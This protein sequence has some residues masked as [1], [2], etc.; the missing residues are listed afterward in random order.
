MTTINALSIGASATSIVSQQ[1][2]P[3]DAPA[4][5]TATSGDVSGES[6]FSP[7][8]LQ[9][10][11]S[12]QT[13]QHVAS[14][15][16]QQAEAI[17]EA[18]EE[19]VAGKEQQTPSQSLFASTN[20]VQELIALNHSKSAA[21]IEAMKQGIQS[22]APAPNAE[23]ETLKAP[24][25]VMLSIELAE[26]AV[27][28]PTQK[29]T[30]ETEM[31]KA[32]SK[33]TEQNQTQK[34]GG[35]ANNNPPVAA[36]RFTEAKLELDIEQPVVK[37]VS[38]EKN[39]QPTAILQQ[40][41][42][43]MRNISVEAAGTATAKQAEGVSSVIGNAQQISSVDKQTKI[44]DDSKTSSRKFEAGHS[45]IVR[46]DKVD[47][48]KNG[49]EHIP[50]RQAESQTDG[51]GG[52]QDIQPKNR[53]IREQKQFA[54][55]TTTGISG[56]ALDTQEIQAS[57]AEAVQIKSE[58]AQSIIEQ[59]SKNISLA[60]NNAKSEMKVVLHPESLGEVV[61]RVQVEE[62]KV[63][64]QLDVQQQQVK[65]MIEQH[66]PQLKEALA[67]K[68]LTVER[69]DVFASELSFKEQ[70]SQQQQKKNQSGSERVLEEQEE[71]IESAK[72]FGYN[73][74]EYVV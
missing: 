4:E 20:A 51:F 8:L 72:L 26:E 71:V 60:L 61:V 10:I 23:Q 33:S 40:Q 14:N 69:I 42:R 9:M 25:G 38:S 16:F 15:Q 68:G 30:P 31:L 41:T 57:K 48:A 39:T 36:H 24:E 74:I 18:M 12:Q 73:T 35:S 67:N 56:I 64:T 62:G 55:H 58:V 50:Q 6:M 65:N 44:I 22:F 2:T 28:I 17:A 45:S 43:Q 66:L 7:L 27:E 29:V 37:Q 54:V 34:A 32:K 70:T 21:S 3:T 1:H 53:E 11:L 59:L 13:P 52:Q 63:T 5:T 19:N 47:A 46:G 49:S